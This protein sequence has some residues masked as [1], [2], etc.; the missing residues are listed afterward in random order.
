[1]KKLYSVLSLNVLLLATGALHAQTLNISPNPLNLTTQ[2]STGATAQL[3]FTS[4]GAAITIYSVQPTVSWLHTSLGTGGNVQTPQTITITVDP[5]AASA[6]G[7]L[8]VFSS[9]SVG[10]HSVPV[11]VSVS[12]IGV[13]PTTLLF[14]HQSGGF[15]AKQESTQYIGMKNLLHGASRRK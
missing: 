11:N 5:L 6:T 13:N 4:T 8:S 12:S 1:M 2:V 14:L 9:D 7:A 10:F 3:T 15:T